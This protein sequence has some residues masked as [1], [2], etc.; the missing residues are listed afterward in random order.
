MSVNQYEKLMN[1]LFWEKSTKLFGYSNAMKANNEELT[2]FFY[3]I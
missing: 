1:D 3:T 2:D